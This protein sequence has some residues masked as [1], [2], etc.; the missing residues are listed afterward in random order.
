[1]LDFLLRHTQKR[2]RFLRFEQ[3]S[4]WKKAEGDQLSWPNGSY[5]A[6]R[7]GATSTGIE[8]LKTSRR[9]EEARFTQPLRT[10]KDEDKLPREL[11]NEDFTATRRGSTSTGNEKWKHRGDEKR[12]DFTGIEE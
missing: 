12:I 6:T 8:E 5:A 10:S 1:M 9:R 2:S 4:T 7:R 3:K 11:K